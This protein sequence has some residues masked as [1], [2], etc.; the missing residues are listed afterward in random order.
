MAFFPLMILAF[1]IVDYGEYMVQATNLTA[2]IR[3]AADYARGHVAQG[4]ALPQPGDLGALL[5]VPAGVFNTTNVC[6]CAD[7][8]MPPPL[9][10]CPASLPVA[11][12]PCAAQ[13]DMRVLSYV[14]VSGLQTYT[15][16]VSGLQSLPGSVNAGAVLRSQ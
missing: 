5:G 8:S 16:F 12:N 14:G 13:A 9:P 3:G 11:P 15:P 1:G 4:N 2:I 10:T 7:G 6:T